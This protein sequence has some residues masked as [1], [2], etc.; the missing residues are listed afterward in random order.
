MSQP[1]KGKHVLLTGANGFV[2]SHILSILIDVR[3]HINRS[4]V[5]HCQLTANSQAGRL[6]R[7]SDCSVS[8]QG[9]RHHRNPSYMEEQHWICDRVRLYVRDTV[10]WHLF[11]GESA[12]RLCDPYRIAI[13]VQSLRY[14]QGDDWARWKRVSL[15]PHILNLDNAKVTSTTEILKATQKYGGSTLKRFVLLGSAVAVLSSFEDMT[16]EGKPY[17]EKD[18]NPVSNPFCILYIP[19]VL[20]S[21]TMTG[22]SWAGCWTKWPR[23]RIQCFENQSRNRS[24]GILQAKQSSLWLD[25]Y[26]PRYHY[27]TDDPSYRRSRLHQWN[28]PFRYRQL[29]W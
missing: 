1:G 25:C 16:K 14:P 29:H 22:H 15:H 19:Q 8:V 11:K 3:T 17:T 5:F 12:I 9:G 24:M 7:D 18:W 27:W 21:Y 4:S 28:Q 23:S 6:F 13:K 10:W 2:A 26:Q 20:T